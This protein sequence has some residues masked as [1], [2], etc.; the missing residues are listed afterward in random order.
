MQSLFPT[1]TDSGSPAWEKI[2]KIL[3]EIISGR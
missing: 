1:D 3:R 2:K